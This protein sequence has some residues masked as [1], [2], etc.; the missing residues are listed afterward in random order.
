MISILRQI[1]LLSVAA[2][3]VAGNNLYYLFANEFYMLIQSEIIK[4]KLLEAKRN[5]ENRRNFDA[6]KFEN[7]LF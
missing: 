6:C 5:D 4:K 7:G 3:V 1:I 2:F